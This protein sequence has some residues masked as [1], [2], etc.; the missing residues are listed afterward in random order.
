MFVKRKKKKL[1]TEEKL[2]LAILMTGNSIR[3]LSPLCKE[4]ISTNIVETIYYVR[5]VSSEGKKIIIILCE[6]CILKTYRAS[7]TVIALRDFTN[8]SLST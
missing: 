6:L 1:P 3:F 4:R 5:L 2:I 8:F 7:V